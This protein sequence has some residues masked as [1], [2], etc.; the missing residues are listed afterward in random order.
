MAGNIIK[1]FDIAETEYSWS[2]GDD[3][4]LRDG[5][6]ACVMDILTRYAKFTAEE[7]ADAVATLGSRPAYALALLDAMEKK[8]V[9][10]S[11]VSAFQAP[12]APPSAPPAP[13]PADAPAD[14]S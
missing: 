3:D 14:R 12:P 4:I 9:P 8:Q 2:I 10:T 6:L 5:A 11:D 1:C 13:R 7:K